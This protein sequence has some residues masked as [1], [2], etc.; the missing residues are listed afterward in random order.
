MSKPQLMRDS[1]LRAL[2][3]MLGGTTNDLSYVLGSSLIGYKM[4]EEK[5]GNRP[6]PDPRMAILVRLLTKYPDERYFPMPVMPTFDEFM[7]VVSTYWVG[8]PISNSSRIPTPSAG[9]IGPLLGVNSSAGYNWARGG[10]YDTVISRLFWV[11]SNMLKLEGKDGMEKYLAVVAEEAEARGKDLREIIKARR[12]GRKDRT[13]QR[14][15]PRQA[16]KTDS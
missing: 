5:G 1:D 16:G 11:I 3:E 4:S 9:V 2:R 10:N 8:E 13:N 15:A 14:T 6:I 12:W 7:E